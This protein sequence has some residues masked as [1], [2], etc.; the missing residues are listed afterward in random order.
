L[1]ARLPFADISKIEDDPSVD[2]IGDLY[3]VDMLVQYV[4]SKLEAAGG[5]VCFARP[6]PGL[7]IAGARAGRARSAKGGWPAGGDARLRAGRRRGALGL[8]ESILGR[9]LF[10]MRWIWIDKFLDFRSGQ[11][12]RAIKNLTLAEEHLH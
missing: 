9:V 2:K 12:A 3:T 7:A 1:K 4:Q 8:L 10:A 5:V 11:F 6:R